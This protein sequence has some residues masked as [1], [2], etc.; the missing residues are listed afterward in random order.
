MLKL[1][2]PLILVFAAFIG[3]GDIIHAC[4][5]NDNGAVRIVS[6]NTTC[7][8]DKSLGKST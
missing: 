8:S 7:N 4:V 3:S 2:L 1:F 5:N 6:A